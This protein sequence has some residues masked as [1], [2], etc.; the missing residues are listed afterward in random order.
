MMRNKARTWL[1]CSLMLMLSLGAMGAAG[2][3]S[4]TVANG[5]AFQDVNGNTVHAHGGGVIKA[6]NYYYWFGENRNSDDT[7]YA[8]SVYRSTDLK[9]WE[10][11]NNVLTMNSAA[12]LNNA[13]IERPKVMYNS[14]TGKFVMWMHKENGSNYSEARAAVASSSTVDGNYTYHGSFRPF[15]EMS[16]DITIFNDNGTGYMISAA[17]NNA[18]MHIYRLTA[19]FLNVDAQ[20]QNLFQGQYREAPAMFKRDGVYFLLTSGATG[21]SPNQQKYATAASIEGA[22]SGLSNVGNATAYDSQTAYVL[23]I[24]GSQTTS[25]LYMGDRW[26]GAWGDKVNDSGYVWLPLEFPT[27]HSMKMDFYDRLQ[28]D[29]GAGTIQG[30]DHYVRIKNVQSGLFIDG[31]GRTSN[32]SAAGQWSDSNSANQ[33][34]TMESAGSYVRI[35]NRATGLYLDGMG[36]TTN[37][38]DA[39][40]WSNSGSANQQWTQE[41]SGGHV[42]LKNR[43]T[44]LYLDG[45]GRTANGANLGQWSNSNSPNQQWIV[46]D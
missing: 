17:N 45:M 18:D 46:A 36:R 43:A 6:G 14:A 41:S 37:G 39:G 7:F 15:G 35:K 5:A 29:T 12:E 16:R 10:F 20:V 22:W 11:R 2:A 26:A 44:G 1:I 23:P 40:Q 32:G 21:W 9:N 42:R 13:K 34:W 4:V 30:A 27:D 28:I 8:V 33:Q 38:A 3:A 31:M 24:A 19:D 25:Y